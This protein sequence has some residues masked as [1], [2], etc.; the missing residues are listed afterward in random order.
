MCVLI[1]PNYTANSP[2]G[3]FGDNNTDTC[4]ELCTSASEVRDYQNNRRCVADSNCSRSPAALFA[5]LVNKICVTA[6]FCPL[7]T[8]A[9]NFTNKC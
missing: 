4:E 8:F 1:C 3:T 9:D 7:S 6:L 2:Q 5:D